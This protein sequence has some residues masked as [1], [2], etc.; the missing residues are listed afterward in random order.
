MYGAWLC[1]MAMMLIKSMAYKRRASASQQPHFANFIIS[2]VTQTYIL[3]VI[4]MQFP[5]HALI[6]AAINLPIDE[7]T[8]VVTQS[9]VILSGPEGRE[10]DLQ[11]KVSLPATGDT[12]LPILLIAH[13]HGDSDWLSSLDGYTGMTDFFAGHGFVVINPTFQ[14]SAFLQLDLYGIPGDE[15]FWQSRTEDLIYI[16]DNLDAIEDVVPLMKGKINKDKVAIMGH[17]FG[18][19]TASLLL[20]AQNTDPRFNTTYEAHDPRIK[21]GVIMSGTGKGG[22]DLSRSGMEQLP[23][24]LP[25]FATMTSPALVVYGDNDTDPSQHLTWRDPDW[26][27]DPYVLSPGP[28][29]LFTVQDGKHSLGGVSGLDA[30]EATD[31][32]PQRLTA[33]QRLTWAYL[34]GQLFGDDVWEEVVVAM[35]RLGELGSVEQK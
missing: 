11:L 6:G 23:W 19:W 27:A 29:T 24:Y 10:V 14:D 25:N 31:A 30:L 9:P 3:T 12:P 35:S 26:H 15:A 1:P 34:R 33:V 16:L 18:G 2:P 8:S 17:S 13:G 20:G 5:Y 4:S 21:T 28:K 22:S 32:S 7:P